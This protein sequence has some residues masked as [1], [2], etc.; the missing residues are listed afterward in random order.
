M[1]LM[2]ATLRT[3]AFL[4]FA[5]WAAASFAAGIPTGGAR[6]LFDITA[7]EAGGL[8]LPSDVAIDSQGR[9][10]V[11]DG[12]NH[13]VLAFDRRGKHLFGI[14]SKGSGA[15]QFLG[16]V[17][18][19]TDG[20]GRIYVA[21]TGNHRIQVFGSDGRFQHAFPVSE[22]GQPVR[23]IDVTAD[24]SGTMIFVTGNNNHKVMEFGAG[25]TPIRQWGGNGENTGQFRYPASIQ[26]GPQGGIFVAD[27]LNSRVQKF[28]GEGSFLVQVSAWGVLPG[29]LFR[30][31]GVA[32]DGK[33]QIYISDSYMDVI[34]VFND[35]GRFL[36]VLGR[37]GSPQR[38]VSVGGISVG[39]DNRLYAAEMLRNKVSVYDIE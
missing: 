25:G 1:S 4:L 29:Q 31:K 23:P 17:G 10:F 38:F 8:S 18:I 7:A 33:G 36:H 19:G 22:G 27:A 21:D 12:G 15:G 13:R 3:A 28:D 32:I 35:E 37:K 30:P 26:I 20:R 2:T 6:H 11:V 14:G 39:P 16:P 9:I 34:Q 24:A 5:G